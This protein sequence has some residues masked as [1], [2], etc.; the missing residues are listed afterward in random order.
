MDGVFAVYENQFKIGVKGLESTDEQMLPIADMESFSVSIDGKRETWT[1]MTAGGWGDGLVTGKD[2]SISLSGK[3][4]IGDPGND[5]VAGLMLAIGRDVKT[6]LDWI[7]PDGMVVRFKV[8]VSVKACGT[9]DSTNVGPLEFD[10]D[11]CG[12]PVVTLPEAAGE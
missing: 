6:Y 4:H 3:R 2:I 12:K 5:Y 8:D 7:F 11:T 9:G 1:S 10:C